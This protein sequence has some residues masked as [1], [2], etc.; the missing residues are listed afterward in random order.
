M[1]VTVSTIADPLGTKLIID[2]DSDSTSENNV[3]GA[4]SGL[5]YAVEIDNTANSSG[6]YTKLLDDS[7]AT[8]GTSQAHWVLFAPASTKLTY[9][10]A[11]GLPFTGALSFW[12]VT[13]A[14]NLTASSSDSTASPASNVSVKILCT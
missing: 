14:Y 4:T 8:P 9:V 1:A 3:T 2:S 12:T 11:S 10:I 5:I 13:S 6:V 7:S